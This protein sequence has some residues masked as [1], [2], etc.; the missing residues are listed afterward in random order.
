[1]GRTTTTI[2]LKHHVSQ[3]WQVSIA[4]NQ[5]LKFLNFEGNRNWY[6]NKIGSYGSGNMQKLQWV[7]LNLI[8]PSFNPNH[9]ILIPFRN[10]FLHVVV[11]SKIRLW[12][13]WERF[14][15]C[16]N[17]KPRAKTTE[18]CLQSCRARPS[19]LLLAPA[20]SAGSATF[21]FAPII[22]FQPR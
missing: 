17:G 4:C 11:P 2:I 13:D 10:S 12:D 21:V 15:C 1:M 8:N 9:S 6:W 19:E 20:S 14:N 3:D 18:L 16:R 5:F 7:S 22:H